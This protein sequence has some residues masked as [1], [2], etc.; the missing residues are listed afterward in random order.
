MWSLCL[1]NLLHST[2]PKEQFVLYGGRKSFI[3]YY[4]GKLTTQEFPELGQHSAS[5]IRAQEADKVLSSIDFRLGINYAFHNTYTKV[6]PTVDVALFRN[7]RSELLL[8]KKPNAHGWRLPGGFV[9]VSDE[10]YEHAAYRELKEECGSLETGIIQYIGSAR[11]D[12]WRYR[13]EDD[14]ILTMLFATD[15]IYGNASPSDDLE[16]VRWFST[17]NL[18]RMMKDQQIVKEHHPLVELLLMKASSNYPT[19]LKN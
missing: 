18:E 7:N 4:H 2:F 10:S 5:E 12:D 13:Q 17:H 6:Y 1:D 14:K 3:E 16:Q 19:I 9:D 15:L 8:G 11:I